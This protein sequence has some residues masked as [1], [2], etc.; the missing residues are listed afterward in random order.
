MHGC[1][2]WLGTVLAALCCL[3]SK[4]RN[5]ILVAAE[6]TNSYTRMYHW[7][8]RTKVTLQRAKSEFCGKR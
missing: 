6:K 8:L 3:Y 7:R 1:N 2:T 4:F 5:Q